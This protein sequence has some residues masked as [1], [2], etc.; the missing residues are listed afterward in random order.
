MRDRWDGVVPDLEQREKA[1]DLHVVSDRFRTVSRAM[2][3]WGFSGNRAIANAGAAVDRDR[4]A[5]AKRAAA[6]RSED[7]DAVIRTL[8]GDVDS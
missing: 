7:L 1:M 8:S 5:A 3:D 6:E 4:R 2:P